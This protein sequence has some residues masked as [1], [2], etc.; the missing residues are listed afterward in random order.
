MWPAAASLDARSRRVASG[1]RRLLIPA[2]AAF[3]DDDK[4]ERRDERANERRN[5]ERRD[6]RS[7]AV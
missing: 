5:H 4:H 7:A 2:Y 3:G 6:Q 1:F